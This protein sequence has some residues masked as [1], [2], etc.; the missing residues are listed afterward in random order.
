MKIQVIEPG[1]VLLRQFVSAEECER[2]AVMA[3]Q[4]GCVESSGE[5]GFYTSTESG[6]RV[7]NTGEARGRIYDAATR[8]PPT[9]IEPCVAAVHEACR[10]DPVMPSMTCTH[11]LL[12]MYTTSDGLVW[13]RDI[14]ENDGTS[15]HPVVNLSLG[16]TGVFGFRHEETDEARTVRLESG[17]VLLFGGPCRWIQHAVLE[18]DLDDCPDWM[19]GGEGQWQGPPC[20]FSFTY[21]D[22]P[23]V[24][25]R[26]HEF[27]Y[28]RV[29]EDLVGQ[30]Q[31]QVPTK[32]T[33]LRGEEQEGDFVAVKSDWQSVHVAAK[34]A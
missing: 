18:I 34:T 1:L 24:L 21:R 6:E 23:E 12:N 10:A 25:G 27:K 9:L 31:F 28:F 3:Q 20:R 14:Y 29:K 5:D 22:S 2:I 15:D 26:E 11:L 13:H 16:A 7:L 19:K 30:G 17:D 33:Q 32:K 4:W 8:F